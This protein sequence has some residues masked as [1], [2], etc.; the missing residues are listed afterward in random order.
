MIDKYKHIQEDNASVY[1]STKDEIFA[2]ETLS[3]LK[4]S[5]QA[6]FKYFRLDID[7]GFSF[8]AYLATNR[9]EFENLVINLL[10][11]DIEIPSRKS[12]IAQ[13][14]GNNLI[15]LSPSAY[16]EDSTY[17]YNIED[18]Q[19]LLLHE[20]THMFQ[21]YLSPDME[22]LPRWFTEGMAI[23]ISEKWKYEDEFKE[24]VL[25]TINEGNTPSFAE[26]NENIILSYIWGWTIIK[27]IVDK[28]GNDKVIEILTNMSLNEYH[29]IINSFFNQWKD[30]VSKKENVV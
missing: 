10:N 19:R 2:K 9:K 18:Y 8:N 16:E 21:E 15:L 23:Y 25:K 28:Y 29:N 30:W 5:Y 14:Q 26:I 20:M 11:I 27:Y 1:Y 22:K 6:L 3:E 4:E 24:S 7:Q 13:P 17:K 12:H